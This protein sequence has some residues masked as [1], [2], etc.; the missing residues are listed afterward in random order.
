MVR[1]SN[2]GGGKRFSLPHIRDDRPR[3]SPSLLYCR[4]RRSFPTAERS[5]PV[6]DRLDQLCLLA[7]YISCLFA[8]RPFLRVFKVD[9]QLLDRRPTGR[10]T[11]EHISRDKRQLL[12][13]PLNSIA[14]AREFSLPSRRSQHVY[15]TLVLSLVCVAG[16]VRYVVTS[17][18]C[19]RL[20]DVMT[21]EVLL[22]PNTLS[23]CTLLCKVAASA[24]VIQHH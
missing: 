10:S 4:Y 23:H 6:A 7:H 1:V 24:L 13:S 9:T 3:G 21:C 2:P 11:P 20:T 5:R 22:I 17:C 14:S 16:H 15:R 18:E 19:G 12:A 8:F